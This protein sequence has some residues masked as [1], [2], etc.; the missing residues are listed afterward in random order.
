MARI[1]YQPATKTKGFQP[2]QL[3]TAGISRM[4]EE[5]NRVVGGMEQ[6]LRAEQEQQKKN[7]QA[8]QDNADY[9]KRITKE[10]REIE[11]QNLK[12]EQLSITQTAERDAQQAKYDA[13]ATQTILSSIVDFSQTAAKKAAANTAKQL[14]D[15]TD[16]AMATDRSSFLNQASL[17][18]NNN[19]GALYP[20]AMQNGNAI[21]EQGAL[22][23]EEISK[24]FKTLSHEPGRGAIANNITVNDL[25]VETRNIFYNKAITGTE[26]MYPDGRGGFF[27][28]L[29]AAQDT[30][31]HRILKKIVREQTFSYIRKA[32]KYTDPNAL[33]DAHA[34][35]NKQE[36]LE[37]GRVE[38]ASVAVAKDSMRQQAAVLY[39][40][41]NPNQL[42]LAYDN[43]KIVDGFK[44]ANTSAFNALVAT[45]DDAKAAAFAAM[46]MPDG[47]TLS[48]SP[49]TKDGYAQAVV[50]RDDRINARNRENRR[51]AKEQY[52]QGR[53]AVRDDLLEKL[54]QPGNLE[55]AA[56]YIAQKDA[57][58]NAQPDP[59]IANQIK[60]LRAGLVNQEAAEVMKR[61]ANDNLTPSFLF[62]IQDKAN[63]TL[64]LENKKQL[65]LIKNGG[66]AGVAVI[67]GYA[68]D[69]RTMVKI[70]GETGN[71]QSALVE[72]T[73]IVLFKK[74]LAENGGNVE[75]AKQTVQ[76]EKDKANHNDQTIA[77]ESLFYRKNKGNRIVFP[78]IENPSD[79]KL[80]AALNYNT[81]LL[82]KGVRIVE[83]PDVL[84]TQEQLTAFHRTK[85]QR[86]PPPFIA[87]TARDTGKDIVEV[88]N[89]Y[90][91]T[92]NK[93]YG[94]SYP[95][96]TP[97]LFT[98][99]LQKVDPETARL[100]SSDN[101]MK[102]T[103]G[104]R[105][106]TGTT[107]AAMRPTFRN[108][109][110]QS[111]APQVSSVTFDTGQPGIDVF[112][113]DHNVPALLGGTVKDIGYQVSPDGSGYG[114]YLVIESI[115]P[116]N[117]EVFDQL[118][119]HLPEE[120]K[121]NIG[122]NIGQGEIIGK[123]GG[124]GS[125]Q[126]F[127]G[128]IASYDFLEAAPRGSGSMTPYANYDPLRRLLASQLNQ[129]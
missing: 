5:T 94:T 83:T 6:N 68:K 63:K 55:S 80:E 97:S 59:V 82:E 105:Q 32:T 23:G 71:A 45:N 100:L 120:P 13:D 43:I 8:M 123:Q 113:E 21:V 107:S 57:E 116:T 27:S 106:A 74:A 26:K 93:E 14:E 127:D 91:E 17:D 109:P 60:I 15:Q 25:T 65:E 87:Q 128:T 70:N 29:E 10:N 90:Q 101:L 31:K 7:L 104:A 46:P 42:A 110:L 64:A 103:R 99:V 114:H 88:Y 33:Q 73:H 115:D 72:A 119:A 79:D 49:F 125:V 92:M 52:V 22:G 28:G 20:G 1:R 81:T 98:E 19:W 36:K 117:G 86:N 48:T 50:R 96:I 24:T 35:I 126:S 34:A 62:N 44:A 54:R 30:D 4:R 12:N 78:K 37:D 66:E 2:I 47:N 56:A 112:Y 40:G 39:S 111:F 121:Q 102:F 77:K 11:I 84:G 122:Q 85:G 61:T 51:V 75:A 41:K 124:T 18:W 76:A 9:T 118:I 129:N 16:V 69:S 89:G 53:T 108:T 67:K 3:S 95:L 38:T 58:N